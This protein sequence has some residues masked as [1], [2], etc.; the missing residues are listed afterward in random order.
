MISPIGASGSPERIHADTTFASIIAPA[1]DAM[2]YSAFRGDQITRTGIVVEQVLQSILS[3]DLVIADL[4][5]CNPNVFYELAIRHVTQKPV[6][7]MIHKNHTVPFNVAPLR[8]VMFSY[9]DDDQA[10]QSASDLT[11]YIKSSLS[12]PASTNPTTTGMAPWQLSAGIGRLNLQDIEFLVSNY[13][14]L[15]VLSSF[16]R[17]GSDN[18]RLC[19]D[20][21]GTVDK[22]QAILDNLTRLVSLPRPSESYNYARY[23]YMIGRGLK[24]DDDYW[25]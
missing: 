22:I 21:A 9:D 13:S 3:S 11:G 1:A 17:T 23:K 16:R 25:K 6:V 15:K 24:G 4:T 18:C 20:M 10:A 5:F 8:T 2:G 14:H 12:D 7:T 19:N